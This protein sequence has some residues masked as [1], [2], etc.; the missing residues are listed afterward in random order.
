[1]PGQPRWQDGS[2]LL[3]KLLLLLLKMLL[4]AAR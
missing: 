1:M 4:Q 2:I 3:S